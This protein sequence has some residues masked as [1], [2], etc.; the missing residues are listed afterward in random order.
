[1]KLI[2][3]IKTC[4]KKSE[5]YLHE[6]K[7]SVLVRFLFILLILVAYFIFVTFRY[8]L[9]NGFM[10]TLLTWSFFVFCT[11]IADA[12]FL[13]DFPL[14]LITKIR[15]IFS[16]I[17]VWLTAIIIN[18]Y[19]LIFK[20]QVYEK[21]LLLRIFKHI[22]LNPIPLYSIILLSALGT[23]L[24]IYFGDELIDVAKHKER[25]KYIKHKNKYKL[26][27]LVFIVIVIFFLYKTLINEF[28]IKV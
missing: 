23:F 1:M 9:S 28:G 17:F 3:R 16:E 27:V 6:T 18:I 20:P 12:G 10:V 7:K 26:I 24:S 5:Y 11:P 2:N 25:K 14:R 22:L 13:I 15:M 19:T 4:Y 21:T 8:G